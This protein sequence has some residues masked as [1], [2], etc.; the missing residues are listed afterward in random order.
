MPAM[1]PPMMMVVTRTPVMMVTPAVMVVART[2][3]VMATP[4][5]MVMAPVL[6]LLQPLVRAGYRGAA[7]DR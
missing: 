1:V 6:D 4:A 7:A 3:V 5:V 2:P